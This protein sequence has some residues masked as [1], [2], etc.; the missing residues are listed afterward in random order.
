VLIDDMKNPTLYVK[1]SN[2][3]LA[4]RKVE[5]GVY[6]RGLV[7]ILDGIEE[8]DVVITSDVEGLEVGAPID[9]ELEEY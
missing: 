8:G 4:L 7:E 5:T 3:E 1:N 2:S 6:D 9:V